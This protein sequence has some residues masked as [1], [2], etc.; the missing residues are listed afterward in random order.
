MLNIKNGKVVEWP[1]LGSIFD[2]DESE[3]IKLAKDANS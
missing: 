3:L 1:H 2:D